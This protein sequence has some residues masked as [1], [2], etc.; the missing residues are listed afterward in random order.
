[1]K[2]YVAY[3]RVSTQK[4][5]NSGLGLEAQKNTVVNF[6]AGNNI[7]AE[8]IEVES[9][10][11]DKREEL[12]KAIAMANSQNAI[13][14]I[15]KL[16]R[17]SRNVSFIFKLR[18][19][20]VN[21]ICCDIPDANTMTIGIFALLAQQERELISERT[22]KALAV[23][24]QQGIKLGKPENLSNKARQNSIQIRQAQA[25]ENENNKRA[26]ALIQVLRNQKK[27]FRTIAESLNNSGFKTSRNNRFFPM[28][29]KQL[30]K[31]ENKI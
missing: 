19:S 24:K 8:Y 15:A 11:K 17:L 7:I 6:V 23:K 20:K 2:N 22:K 12:G 26:M 9:G 16:D 13:L 14:I 10:K 5:G 4:Q 18:D 28:S 3:Y 30:L 27:T 25:K 21:F 31:Q 1:M 29:V